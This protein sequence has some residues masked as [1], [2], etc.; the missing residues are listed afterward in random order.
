MSRI[1]RRP[2]TIIAMIHTGP[3]PGVTGYRSVDCALERAIAEAKVFAELGVDALLIENTH[4]LPGLPEHHQGPEVVTMMTRVTHNV[5]RQVGDL[6]VGVKVVHGADRSALSVAL[7]AQCDFVRVEGWEDA[8][9]AGEVL[10]YRRSIGAEH[11]PIFAD[12]PAVG[13][14]CNCADSGARKLE[15]HRADGI[16]VSGEPGANAPDLDFVESVRECSGLPILV[17]GGITLDNIEEYADLADGFIIG[18]AFKERCVWNAPVCEDRVRKILRTVH[19]ARTE[20]DLA[21]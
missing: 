20:A 2:K 15:I 9:H 5:K 18:S 8:H 3:S 7:T 10:R 19:H 16:V 14:A 13:Q 21:A 17:A 4:D 12:I 6:P 1:F 11:I